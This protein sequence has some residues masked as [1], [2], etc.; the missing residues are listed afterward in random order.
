VKIL[1]LNNQNS[2]YKQIYYWRWY[3]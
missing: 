1:F 2:C 3:N